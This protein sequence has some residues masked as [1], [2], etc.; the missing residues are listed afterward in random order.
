MEFKIIAVH[1]TF[2]K[3]HLSCVALY[4]RSLVDINR[5]TKS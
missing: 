4:V 1:F 2:F 3:N 5:K